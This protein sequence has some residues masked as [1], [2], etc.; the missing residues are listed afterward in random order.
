MDKLLSTDSV[1]DALE[2][3]RHITEIEKDGKWQ[4]LDPEQPDEVEQLG[5][6]Y[7]SLIHI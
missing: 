1:E 2:C 4:K 5:Q 7:L 6:M 3:I